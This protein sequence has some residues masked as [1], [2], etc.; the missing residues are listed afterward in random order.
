MIQLKKNNV[1]N[2]TSYCVLLSVKR[3]SHS[4]PSFQVNNIFVTREKT[5]Q[6]LQLVE[7]DVCDID[8]VS[9]LSFRLSYELRQT[10]FCSSMKNTQRRN[11]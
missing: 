8:K 3:S 7:L 2:Y 11:I 4:M 10:L 6:R 1:V 9:D 5:P